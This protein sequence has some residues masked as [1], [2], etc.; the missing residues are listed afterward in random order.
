[1]RLAL[2]R[3]DSESFTTAVS[4]CMERILIRLQNTVRTSANGDNT[5]AESRTM[6][7]DSL[8]RLQAAENSTNFSFEERMQ[9]MRFLETERK[10]LN[11]K[12]IHHA[13]LVSEVRRVL[14]GGNDRG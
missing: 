3:D 8:N 2:E 5:A 4:W 14:T 10:G 7:N 9:E 13:P 12:Q 6:D 11:Y 1:M